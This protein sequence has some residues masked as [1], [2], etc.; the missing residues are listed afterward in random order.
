MQIQ[1]VKNKYDKQ[2]ILS[3][4]ARIV[5]FI[6]P[7][8]CPATGELVDRIGMVSADYWKHLNFIQPPF[9]EACGLPFPHDD[10]VGLCGACIDHTP[11]YR[12]A[13]AALVYDDNSRDLILRFKHGDQTQA[14][15]V[16]VPWMIQAGQDLLY[17]ADII[18]PVPLHRFRLLKRRYNQ[19][20]LIARALAKHYPQAH[21]IPD[22]LVRVKNTIPQ[23]H[24]SRKQRA[25]NIRHAF[26]IHP[27]NKDVFT[28][29]TVLIIDDVYT[30]GATVN[31]CAKT[32][33]GAGA[34]AVDVLTIAKIV[35]T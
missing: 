33:L 19:A 26:D 9:C 11:V 16:F 34:K 5:D 14:T 7:P 6:L 10:T 25:D 4:G 21:Y 12:H 35:R 23:G 15:N 32:L 28:G 3:V 30:T 17:Q 1:R 29:K 20:G 27:R 22:G 31:E 18:I 24:Q 13:R 8:V 2:T